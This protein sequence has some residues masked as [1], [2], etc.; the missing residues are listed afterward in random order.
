[1]YSLYIVLTFGLKKDSLQSF[2]HHLS[3]H[4]SAFQQSQSISINLCNP[5]SAEAALGDRA[6][7]SALVDLQCVPASGRVQEGAAVGGLRGAGHA[8]GHPAGH[9][10]CL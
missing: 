1:M 4:K 10:M 7:L 8:A 6:R 2:F 3:L 5:S 9:P